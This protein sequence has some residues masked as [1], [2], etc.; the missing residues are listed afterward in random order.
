MVVAYDKHALV[1]LVCIPGAASTTWVLSLQD[2][3]RSYFD[4]SISAQGATD[5][6]SPFCAA[7]LL[8]VTAKSKLLPA[9][10]DLVASFN[11]LI[12]VLNVAIMHIPAT[13]RNVD[14]QD[15]SLFPVRTESGG[16]DTLQS[17]CLVNKANLPAVRALMH[18]MDNLL[19][20]ATKAVP[21]TTSG[22]NQAPSD[23]ATSCTFHPGLMSDRAI[24]AAVAESLDTDYQQACAKSIDVDER[25][26]LGRAVEAPPTP[27]PAAAPPSLGKC[28]VGSPQRQA[29]DIHL[30]I[31]PV[32]VAPE[33]C[34][35]NWACYCSTS[36]YMYY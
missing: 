7:W 27:G 29:T 5:K 20:D 32:T 19:K 12:C 8:F 11:L 3:F 30:A 31:L 21:S 15:H 13:H 26:F 16:T 25:S 2:L 4:V 28:L 17:L 22:L 1:H 36:N 6:S 10:P 24:T 34:C 14:L 35:S 18:G 23:M 33:R 9:F